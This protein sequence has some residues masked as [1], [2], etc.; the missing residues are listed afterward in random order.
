MRLAIKSGAE[1]NLDVPQKPI[2]LFKFL[3]LYAKIPLS[4]LSTA[5]LTFGFCICYNLDTNLTAFLVKAGTAVF[6]IWK[7]KSKTESLF[8]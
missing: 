3:I 7:R 6:V 2:K 8:S 1:R 4:E 5:K